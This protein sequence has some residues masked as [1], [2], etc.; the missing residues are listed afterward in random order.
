MA[1][2]S[3][4]TAIQPGSTFSIPTISFIDGIYL[5]KYYADGIAHQLMVAIRH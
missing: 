3:V 1:G 4:Y 2:Q 5:L